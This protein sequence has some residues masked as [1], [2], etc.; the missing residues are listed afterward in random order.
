MRSRRFQN[1]VSKS[2]LTLPL[3]MVLGAFVW[4][5]NMHANGW[6]H[7]AGSVAA[8]IS[9]LCTTCMVMITANKFVLLRIRSNMV[10]AVWAA[11][12]SLMPFMHHWSAGWVAAPALA[13]SHY[14]MFHT[15]QDRN[16]SVVPIFHTFILLGVASLAVPQMLVFVPL[17]YWHLSVFM[18]SMSWRGL[19]A[20]VVGLALPLCFVLGWSIV[21]DDYTFLADRWH[22]LLSTRL[23]VAEDY[24][25]MAD[26][27]SPRV[28]F[29][30]FTTLLS[31]VSIVHYLRN[32]FNDKIRT[33][34]YLYIY[35]LQTVACWL[36][37]MSM[38]AGFDLL[39]PS[40]MLCASPMVAH[41][42]ALTGTWASNAFFCLTLLA[43]VA[44]TLINI[45]L[46]TH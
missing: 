20:G 32:Y 18:R 30:A 12:L 39:A 26:Y 22:S 40:L 28:R 23:F 45:G 4:F 38:P 2:P 8:L 43:T 5:W 27:A 36:M 46:W 11:G 41:F 24:A 25:W 16:S 33:R 13:A 6:Q 17:S 29:L 9:V 10:T 7:V 34:M 1:I 37:V 19:W 3:C 44:L 21:A 15:Y 42:F 14:V 35:V 31:A